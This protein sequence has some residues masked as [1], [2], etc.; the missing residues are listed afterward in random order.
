MGRP[1]EFD[2]SEVLQSAAEVFRA[3]GYKATSTRDLTEY[4]G[5]TSASLYNAFTDK[6]ALYLR[7]LAQYL[8]RTLR[9]RIVR[10]E[11]L[12]SPGDAI[13]GFFKEVVERSLADPRHRGCLL[14]NTALEATSEDRDLQR[15][16][17]NHTLMMERFFHGRVVAG[18][19]AGEIPDDQAADDIAKLLLSVA[20]GLRVLVRV[21]P[22]PELLTGLVRPAM[23]MLNLPWPPGKDTAH[24]AAKKAA[25]TSRR[26]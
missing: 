13:V 11:A 4:T 5:L 3:K 23:A 7:A 16:V 9:A 8:D 17:A 15:F 10:L 1:R 6:R 25:S 22:D 26:K 20:M 21:R 14:V 12:P 18:Q 19:R 2:E 24:K